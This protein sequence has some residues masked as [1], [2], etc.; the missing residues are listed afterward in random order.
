MKIALCFYGLPRLIEKCHNQISHYFI[1]GND[2]DVYAHFWWDDSYKGKIN[3]LHIT[4]KFDETEN[5][6]ETF[7]QLYSPKGLS[8]EECPNFET[9]DCLLDG[10][11]YPTVEES[12]TFDKIIGSYTGYTFYTRHL[13]MKK[14]LDLVSNPDDYDII[15]VLRTDLLLF[16]DGKLTNEII[17]LDFNK[18]IY[19]PSTLF[20]GPVFAGEF[21]NRLGDWFIA[22][23]YDNVRKFLDISLQTI[24]DKKIRIPIH[25]QERYLFFANLANV[26]LEKYDS[27]ISIRRYVTEEWEDP[28]Y[29]L[30]RMIHKDFYLTVFSST[31]EAIESNPILPFYTKNIITFIGLTFLPPRRD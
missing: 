22:S 2:C 23:K 5:P 6:I 19:M 25:N 11:S 17:S 20:G 31:R 12:N 18:H 10:W 9:H 8:Y 4:E 3:R 28:A 7:K 15:I 30:K 1:D 24:I 14:S 26:T 27:S 13:S 29:R 21:P 16:R